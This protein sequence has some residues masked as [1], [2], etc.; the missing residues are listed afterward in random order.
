M[1][2]SQS[3]P[4]PTQ[5]GLLFVSFK[6]TWSKEYPPSFA[7]KWSK[8]YEIY[9][10]LIQ[11]L[12]SYEEEKD[13]MQWA[14]SELEAVLQQRKELQKKTKTGTI[15]ASATLGTG[16][17]LS[18]VAAPFTGGLSLAVLGIGAAASAAGAA[19]SV[20]V[21]ATLNKKVKRQSRECRKQKQ[22][23]QTERSN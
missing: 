2:T 23:S 13:D 16:V 6:R 11:F 1:G 15:A 5:T 20:G 10:S 17:A 12:K 14:V 21:L 3:N 22:S 4:T 8:H 7:L 18:I 19:T 9:Q